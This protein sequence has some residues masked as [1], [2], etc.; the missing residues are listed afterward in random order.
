MIID[1]YSFKFAV[2]TNFVGFISYGIHIFLDILTD[3]SLEMILRNF[4]DFVLLLICRHYE[5]AASL[6]IYF[7]Q[8][9]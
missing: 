5:Y 3:Y 7:I 4:P 1:I 2:T 9:S 8:M 6:H